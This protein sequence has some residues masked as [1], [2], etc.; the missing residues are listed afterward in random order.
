MSGNPPDLPS[1]RSIGQKL[2]DP[3]IEAI[4]VNDAGLMPS[5]R[6]LGS[7]AIQSIVAYVTTGKRIIVDQAGWNEAEMGPWLKYGINGYRRFLDPDGYPAIKPPWATLSAIDLNTGEFV[8][9]IPFGEYPAL[10][11]KGITNTGCKNF[12]GPLVTTGGLLFIAATNCDNKFRAY[13][14]STS[15]LLWE[16]T[17]PYAGNATPATYEVNGRQFIVIGAGGGHWGAE[18][19]GT[20]VAFALPKM[21]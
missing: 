2:T 9:K 17:L 11:E 7:S 8:W 16:G 18:S 1:L 20:Y 10:V 19:G 14:K 6:R 5:F 13:D 4:L 12:G 15:K 21:N 3:D